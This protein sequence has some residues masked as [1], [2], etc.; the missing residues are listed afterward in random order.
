M[1]LLRKI[2]WEWKTTRKICIAFRHW[3]R[4]LNMISVW[5]KNIYFYYAFYV[6]C[7]TLFAIAN[8]ISKCLLLLVFKLYFLYFNIRSTKLE[9]GCNVRCNC[10]N[11]SFFSLLFTLCNFYR[12]FTSVS[13]FCSPY[14]CML[15]ALN[16]QFH[17]G[18]WC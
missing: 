5:I 14:K 1:R 2:Y 6:I 3:M 13:L 12:R 18:I 9:N 17:K 8:S 10:K 4:A 11:Y 15:L 16:C 7:F